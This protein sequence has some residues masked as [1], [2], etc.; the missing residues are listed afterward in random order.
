[1]KKRGWVSLVPEPQ[2][3]RIRRSCLWATVWGVMFLLA[4]CTGKIE[5]IAA[6]PEAESNE[7]L[8]ALLNAGLHADR[9]LGK[10]GMVSVLIAPEEVARALDV[11]RAQGLPREKTPRMG[12]VF[13]KEGLISSPL[14]EKARFLFSLS[15]ELEN[16]LVRI[17]GVVSAR[18]HVVLPESPKLGEE[19]SVQAS[20]AVFIKHR[21]EFN[22]TPLLPQIRKLVLYSIPNLAPDRVS[23][24]L[25]PAQSDMAI[26]AGPK[27]EQV[28]FFQVDGNSAGALRLLLALLVTLSVFGLVAGGLLLVHGKR[29]LPLL[30]PSKS[31]VEPKL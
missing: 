5:L 11:L 7:V 10:E 21:P 20:A 24:V 14:E 2:Q 29:L 18:V 27:L 6:V 19:G 31:S 3:L 9:K 23:V 22:L 12:D 28:L 1:M 15:Q 25:V 30:W 4:A 26:I 16:T 17:D 8:S 13:K